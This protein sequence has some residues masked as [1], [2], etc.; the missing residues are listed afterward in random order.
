MSLSYLNAE[1]YFVI[2]KLIT[3]GEGLCTFDCSVSARTG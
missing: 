2:D 1:G 3:S